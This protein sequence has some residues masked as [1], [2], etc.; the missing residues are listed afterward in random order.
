[1]RSRFRT[2]SREGATESTWTADA[3]GDRPVK[4]E[5]HALRWVFPLPPP[6]PSWLSAT[7]TT[8]GR[9]AECTLRLEG[10]HVS[11]H[12]AT[13]TRSGPLWIVSDAESKNG[14]RVNGRPVREQ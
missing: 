1:M 14:I 3:D 8:I 5:Q 12:H 2:M 9:S 4:T 6:P 13:I 7:R 11:R 10:G